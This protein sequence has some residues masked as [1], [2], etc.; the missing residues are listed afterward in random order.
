M[1]LLVRRGEPLRKPP[2]A[3]PV[4]IVPLRTITTTWPLLLGMGVLM[5]GAGLQ[6]T[7]LGLRATLEGFPTPVTG[8]VMSCYYLGYLLGTVAAPRLLRQV[9][10][11]RVFA[12]LAAVASAAILVQASFVHPAIWAAMR[13]ISGLCFAGIYV[14]AESWLNDRASQ[15]NRGRLLAVY[16]VVLYVG[17]G[18]AQFLLILSNPSTP[19]PFMLVSVLISLSMVP[20]VVSAQQI[21]DRAVPSKVRYRDL[22]RNSPLGVVAVSVSGMISAIIFSMGPVYA[23]LSGLG[24]SGIATFMAVSILA[25]VV[26]QYPVGRLSDRMDRR[27]VIA[28]VCT[29][30]TIVAGSIAAVGAMPRAVF[31]LLAALFSGFA[32][33]LYSLAVSHVNDKLEPTQ[34]VA[35]SSALLRLNGGAAAIGPVLAGSLIAAFGP[36]AYFATLATLTGALTV[37][38]LWRKT[39]RSPVPP[40]RKGP[41]INAQ[42]QGMTGQIV[43][44]AGLVQRPG[45]QPEVVSRVD[46]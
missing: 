43:G 41:F 34:M 7:L 5:L 40:A 25:A 32:L 24:N 28:A 35:A 23:R 6:G 39:R 2:L 12:A 33:T 37:Y 45:R 3:L 15:A 22:Y 42:P 14:V 18:V 11:I 17:L 21:P 38:D 13:L 19:V 9:G 16:M 29:L 31:L 10:H 20:I 26:T 1:H 36:P 46:V 27:T 44:N 4:H 8:V 30:A